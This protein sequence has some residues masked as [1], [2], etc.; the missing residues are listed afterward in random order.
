MRWR[1][2]TRISSSCQ[3]AIARQL[4]FAPRAASVVRWGEAFLALHHLQSPL[5]FRLAAHL[6]NSATRRRGID[7]SYEVD[8]WT[9]L[10]RFPRLTAMQ[11]GVSSAILSK[12]VKLLRSTLYA[13]VRDIGKGRR[14]ALERLEAAKIKISR[15]KAE[16]EAA[17]TAHLRQ[18]TEHKVLRRCRGLQQLVVRPRPSEGDGL[19]V[20][21]VGAQRGVGPEPT[22]RL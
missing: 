21:A 18:A 5:P 2:T 3:S 12:S 14:M 20:Q 6:S 16:L 10:F 1:L 13:R 11:A 8:R 9:R 4:L 19:V 15:Q 22:P 7:H 17:E